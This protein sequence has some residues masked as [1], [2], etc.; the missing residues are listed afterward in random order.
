L[1][2]FLYLVY[3]GGIE[4]TGSLWIYAFPSLTL[5]L[6]GLKR[7]LIDIAIFVILLTFMFVG[8]DDS[9]LATSYSSEYKLRLIFSF[10]VVTFLSSLYEYSSTKS[11]EEM[12][13]LTEKLIN[14]A[15]QDQL[16]DLANRRGIH[17]EMEHLYQEA[18]ENNHPLCVMLCDIDFLHDINDR[19][20][21]EVGDMVIKEVAEEIQKSIN[22]SHTVA[23]W[24][25]E[26][27]LILLPETKLE[28]ARHFATALEQRIE[29]LVINCDRK[30]IRV[31]LSTG[32]SDIKSVN[33][34]YSAIRHAD[35]EMYQLKNA[36]ALA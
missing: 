26:E 2:L 25:G 13:L 34:I 33:S 20:G 1:G 14:V 15:K 6:H 24:S 17:E 3:S 31:T 21:H 12:H 35:N 18:K 8:I 27:F 23:R 5:F 9:L 28:D 4:N 10:L 32:I 29:N 19:Y 11:F 22:N 30:P 16:T 7:G 36:A